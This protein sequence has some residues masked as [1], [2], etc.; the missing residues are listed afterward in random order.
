[1]YNIPVISME[2]NQTNR[3]IQYTLIILKMEKIHIHTDFLDKQTA[4][5]FILGESATL[6]FYGVKHNTTGLPLPHTQLPCDIQY[7]FYTQKENY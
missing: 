1:M 2:W 6:R 7:L 5:F 3:A 4:F